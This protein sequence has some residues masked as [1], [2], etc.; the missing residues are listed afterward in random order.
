MQ[1][2]GFALLFILLFSFGCRKETLAPPE[3]LAVDQLPSAMEKAFSNA[4]PPAKD[5]AT[6][7]VASVQAQDY[8]KAFLDI[9][10]LSASPDLTKEQS[11]ITTRAM[12]TING[13][14]KSAVTKGDEKSATALKRYQMTK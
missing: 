6:Q 9:Q 3:P 11:S 8:S 12:M 5:L 10:S 14:L 2:S 13:L 7:V 1:K 4:K